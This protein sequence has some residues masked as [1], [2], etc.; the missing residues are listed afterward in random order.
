MVT[1]SSGVL[2]VQETLNVE[3][4]TRGAMSFVGLEKTFQLGVAD[5]ARTVTALAT[6]SRVEVK[7]ILKAVADKERKCSKERTVS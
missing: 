1:F 5:C 6:A 4:A 3:P 7:R 2:G